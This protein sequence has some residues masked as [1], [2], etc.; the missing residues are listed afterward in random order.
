MVAEEDE[1]EAADEEEDATAGEMG[2]GGLDCDMIPGRMRTGF[3]EI[4]DPCAS[5]SAAREEL[6]DEE[7][8]EEGVELVGLEAT[9]TLLRLSL[10]LYI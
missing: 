9:L 2:T 4:M 8:E 10:R 5:M 3:S 7:G 1:E 6:L